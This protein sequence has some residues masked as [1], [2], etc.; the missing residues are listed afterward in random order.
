[1]KVQEVILRAMA[2]KITWWQAA[3]IIGISDRQMRRWHERYEEFGFRGLFD[4]RRG[5]P[6]PKKV[7][8]AV[9]E[10]VLGLYREKYFDLNVRHFHEKLEEEHQ[11]EISYSWVKGLL[12]GA[13][14]VAKGRK[15]GVHRQQRPRRPLPGMLLHSMHGFFGAMY[16]VYVR[17]MAYLAAH[18][19]REAAVEFQK[20]LDHPGIVV[21]DP[22]GALARLQLGRAYM[23]FGDRTRAK[24]AYQDFLNLWK[25]A[26]PEIPIFKQANAEYASLS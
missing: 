4:R 15:R 10:K 5:K 17:G 11:V 18:Q 25:D 19:G 1:M 13:G 2:K 23:M 14:M 6:S 9:V 21:S 20:I 22:I 3:Q 26:D 7:P 16:P 8:L 12:Q 24:S